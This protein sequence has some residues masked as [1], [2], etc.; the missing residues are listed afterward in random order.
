MKD[1]DKEGDGFISVKELEDA[2]KRTYEFN[3]VQGSPWKMYVSIAHQILVFHNVVEDVMIFEHDMTNKKLKEIVKANILAEKEVA[4]RD[5]ILD[6]KAKDL[7]DRK[8][9]YAATKLQ[10]F[11]WKWTALRDMAKQRWKLEQHELSIMRKKE[12]KYALLWQ[13][14][15]RKYLAKKASW[16]RVQMHYQKIVEIEGGRGVVYYYN[17]LTGDKTPDKPKVFWL[18]LNQRMGADID[19]PLPWTLHYDDEGRQFWF[20][21]VDGSTE[22]PDRM[23]DGFDIHEIPAKK[24]SGYKICGSCN[25]ELEWKY[26]VDCD[27][28]FCFHC[29]RMNHNFIGADRHKW[30]MCEAI[31][32]SLCKK[33]VAAKR[34]K[35]KELCQK[36]FDRLEKSGVF[37]GKAVGKIE[38]V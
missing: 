16:F 14:A 1:I 33:N 20:N 23:D 12:K 19:D 27:Y 36:C 32:C 35:G 13:T 22:L 17:H 26:C 24:P 6:M 29:F 11:Y 25:I 5:L 3:G 18:L 38:D 28:G 8:E 7:N 31:I 10:F 30:K 2:M 15:W 9:Y 21:R 37:R 4:E 34:A